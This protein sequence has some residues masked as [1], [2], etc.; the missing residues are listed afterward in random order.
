MKKRLILLYLAVLAIAGTASSQKVGLKS[1]LLA[2]G[3]LSP[4]IGIEVGL[5]PKWTLDVTGEGNF[6]TVNRHKWKHWLVQPEARYWFCERFAGHFLGFH[7]LGGVYNFGNIKNSVNFLGSDFSGLSDYRYQG[8]AAGAGVA[9]GYTWVLNDHWNFEL[10]IG[11]GWIY[12]RYDKYPCAQCG[13]ALE[14][15]HPHNYV[16]PTKAAV[17]LVYVF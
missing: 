14:K 15:D 11:V 7:A 3:F 13:T 10:E 12:T 1:N 16:G 4:N 9:Y 5:S 2:D 17:N 8:W 6:W